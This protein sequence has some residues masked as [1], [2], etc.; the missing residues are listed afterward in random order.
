MELPNWKASRVKQSSACDLS[1]EADWRKYFDWLLTRAI[2]F[3][4]EFGAVKSLT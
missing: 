3:R 2:A 1:D 4:K